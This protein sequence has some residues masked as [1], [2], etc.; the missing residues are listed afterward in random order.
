MS[1]PLLLQRD[2][3]VARLRLNRPELHNAFDA[4]LIA[5]L[6]SVASNTREGPARAKV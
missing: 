3:A 6:T 1:D 2:G 4:G 5:A